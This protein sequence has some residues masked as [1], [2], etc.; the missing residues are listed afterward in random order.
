MTRE[1]QRELKRQQ[2]REQRRREREAWEAARGPLDLPFLLLT[3]I[4]LVIGL[5][6]LLSA[7]F[8]SAQAYKNDPLHYFKRQAAFA[9]L[10]LFAMFTISKINYQRFRGA[11]RMALIV[12]IILLVLVVRRM[13]SGVIDRYTGS[14]IGRESDPRLAGA[15]EEIRGRLK[16]GVLIATVIGCVVAVFPV[17]Y[18]FTL[19][20]ALGTVM[21]AF[22][23]LNTVLDIV[24]A[25]AYI[26]VLGD[27]L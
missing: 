19:P 26:K 15:D 24:F 17:V 10:G 27:C 2:V 25:V 5:I 18:M 22:G 21:E 23:P 11:A 1:E 13:L 14:P 4:L 20:R 3:L 12:S 9:A 7:S 16:R 8:P 6:M